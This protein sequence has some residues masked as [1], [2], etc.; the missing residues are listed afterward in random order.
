MNKGKIFLSKL[1]TNNYIKKYQ[2]IEKVNS[3]SDFNENS[4]EKTKYEGT[5]EIVSRIYR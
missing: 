2:W 3:A 5:E 1:L 4:F